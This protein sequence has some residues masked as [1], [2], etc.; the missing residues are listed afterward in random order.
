MNERISDIARELGRLGGK[1]SK[2]KPGALRRVLMDVVAE[3]GTADSQSVLGYWR[4]CSHSDQ[5]DNS[6]DGSASFRH[7][8]FCWDGQTFYYFDGKRDQK[9]DSATICKALWKIRNA[10]PQAV[11]GK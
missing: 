4:R 9:T 3:I 2:R 10:S 7:G 6:P 8:L 11:N 1:A 5:A